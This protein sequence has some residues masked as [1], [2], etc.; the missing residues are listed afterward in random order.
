MLL[1]IGTYDLI[2]LHAV[3]AVKYTAAQSSITIEECKVM[4]KD[5]VAILIKKTALAIEKLSNQVLAPYE[6]SNAQYKIMMMLYRNP[7]KTVRQADIEEKFSLT[8]PTVTGIIQ[9]LE[10]KGLIQR[11]QNPN[12]KRSKLLCLTAK[13]Y[14][15]RDELEQLGESLESQVTEQLTEQECEHLC[16]LL[17]KMLEAH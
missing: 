8:N 13:S 4:R 17:K 2:R 7:D 9:N 10:K 5:R 12:D 11:I 6:L 16:V 3:D 15:I 14:E 1:Y